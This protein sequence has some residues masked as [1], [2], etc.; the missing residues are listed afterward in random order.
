VI[1]RTWTLIVLAAAVL[2]AGCAQ[3][4]SVATLVVVIAPDGVSVLE[5]DVQSIPSCVPA[6]S[7]S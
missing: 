4:S 1:A 6:A 3:T 5:T 7:A 2:M